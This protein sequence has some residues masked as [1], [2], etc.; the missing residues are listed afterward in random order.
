MVA[1][2]GGPYNLTISS[3]LGG[4]S[5]I[6][7]IIKAGDTLLSGNL[8]FN[9]YVDGSGNV[10][11]DSFIINASNANGIYEIFSDGTMICRTV[12]TGINVI[13][14]SSAANQFGSTSG[15]IYYGQTTWTYPYVF[16][17]G[18][19]VSAATNTTGDASA[20]RVGPYGSS[21]CN[22]IVWDK[23]LNDAVVVQ[24]LA[25]GKWK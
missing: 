19:A 16:L 25:I 3:G 14:S 22:I 9:I 6:V 12:G 4:S 18:I 8:F 7:P 5:I 15:T 23:T 1:A 2:S 20:V 17:S 10:T 13:A 24:A 21:T 11:S